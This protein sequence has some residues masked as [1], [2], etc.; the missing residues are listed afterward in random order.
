VCWRS[1]LP[2]SVDVPRQDRLPTP[3]W[4]T[5]R[6]EINVATI[7]A[8]LDIDPFLFLFTPTTDPWLDGP[9]TFLGGATVG[10]DVEDVKEF[11][12]PV[13]VEAVALQE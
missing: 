12:V 3:F 11:G 5:Y 13:H 4:G 2:D 8:D 6:S 1:R 7:G 10:I 9:A